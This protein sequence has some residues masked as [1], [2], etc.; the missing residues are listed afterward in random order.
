MTPMETF[1]EDLA[2]IDPRLAELL[3]EHRRD[4]DEV[5][6]DVFL[7]EVTRFAGELAKQGGPDGYVLDGLL[8][9]IERAVT[10]GD[11]DVE[12]LV[13]VSFLENLH[14]AGDAYREIAC[15]LGPESRRA[16]DLVERER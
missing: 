12:E 6:P 9:A 11:A 1:A 13:V 8:A 15:R 4:N 14:Q 16:L 7:G 3:A 5:L 10:S 2:R